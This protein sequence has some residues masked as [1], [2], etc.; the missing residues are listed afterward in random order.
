MSA[1]TRQRSLYLALESS[2]ATDPS[3]DGSGY[4]PVPCEL[5]DLTDGKEVIATAYSTGRPW[6]TPSVPGRDMAEIS[7]SI[8]LYGLALSAGDGTDAASVTDDALD[9]LLQHIFGTQ[10]DTT[11][12]GVGTGST[13]SSLVLD[14]DVRSQ[15]DLVPV[16]E[17]GLPT[18]APRTQWAYLASDPG[19]GTYDVAPALAAAP[20]TAAVAYGCHVFRP[21]SP[22]AGGPTLAC[23]YVDSEVGSYTCL[24]G[25]VTSFSISGEPGQR[26]MASVT[27]RFDRKSEDATAKTGLPAALTAP[28]TSPLITLLSPVWFGGAAY[29]TQTFTLDLGITAAE[30]TAT[31]GLNARAADEVITLSPTLSIAP[32][33]TDAITN[34]KRTVTQGVTLVQFGGG[35]LSGGVLNA[36]AC[37]FGASELVEASMSDDNGHGRQSV[38]INAVDSGAAAPFVQIA[39][40]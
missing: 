38:T 14:S 27:V 36:M 26:I 32:L 9:L 40:A 5:G 6:P 2:Y 21:N 4:L 29:P 3:A 20:T 37:V 10:T 7:F 22:L 15:Y 23:V 17:P 16:F 24:G 11:G 13:T 19:S 12:E 34:L 33:R 1:R 28:A 30:I 35:V 31:S 25:R 8:P 18:A 39:R